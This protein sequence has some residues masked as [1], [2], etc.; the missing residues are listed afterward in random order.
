[1]IASAKSWKCGSA[2]A[3]DR[4]TPWKK[5]ASTSASRGNASA[6]SRRKRSAN[7]AIRPAAV[8]CETICR[9]YFQ[10]VEQRK[11]RFV[12]RVFLVKSAKKHE[13]RF[14]KV[15]RAGEKAP[16]HGGL[17]RGLH[18]GARWHSLINKQNICSIVS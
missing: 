4:N 6:R 9:T 12:N 18:L 7:S 2:S 1:M 13:E 14:E 3:M 17:K 11:T 5:S 8:H 16:H 15:C 10:P